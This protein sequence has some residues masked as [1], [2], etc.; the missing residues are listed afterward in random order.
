MRAAGAMH[1]FLGLTVWA[2]WLVAA[3]GGLSVACMAAAPPR[4]AGV[5]N[6]IS[7]GLAVLTAATV[8]WLLMSGQALRRA[9]AQLP[10]DAPPRDRFIGSV[11]SCLYFVAAV[12]TLFVGL[13]VLVLS[14]CL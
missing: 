10:V 2:V 13:P 12:A 5:V 6:G 4:D 14:P 9:L 8:A 7:I 1:L 11:S 3:Y